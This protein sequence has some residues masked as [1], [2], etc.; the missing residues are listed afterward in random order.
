[1]TLSTTF[2]LIRM[3]VLQRVRQSAQGGGGGGVGGGVKPRRLRCENTCPLRNM[4]TPSSL[5]L[6]CSTWCQKT[7]VHR[8]EHHLPL[9]HRPSLPTKTKQLHLAVRHCC[10]LANAKMWRIRAK[11][12]TFSAVGCKTQHERNE[13]WINFISDE[14]ATE[15]TGKLC[16]HLVRTASSMMDGNSLSST[17]PPDSDFKLWSR[18]FLFIF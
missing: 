5:F 11:H 7:R 13:E 16:V 1:M 10:F 2:T 6:S 17:C 8:A 3:N 15:T 9:A 4:R 14:S 12:F 18:M